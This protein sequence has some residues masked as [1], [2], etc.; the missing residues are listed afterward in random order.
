MQIETDKQGTETEGK[1]EPLGENKGSLP[2]N[3]N[4]IH[5]SLPPIVGGSKDPWL[6]QQVL[7]TRTL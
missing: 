3:G 1:D 7:N 6:Q 4:Q 2:E 5:I